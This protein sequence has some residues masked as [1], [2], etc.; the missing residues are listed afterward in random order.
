[1]NTIGDR[2]KI[3][4]ER[5]N[6]TQQELASTIN[7]TKQTIYK[8]EN[9]I[10]TNIPSDKLEKIS[11]ALDVSP[12]YLMGWEENLEQANTDVLVDLAV[13]LEAMNHVEKLLKLDDEAKNAVYN[14]IDILSAKKKL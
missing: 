11:A 7:S 8:Y 9:N 2:I 1:M 12:A 13:D 3:M 10:I 14:M 6:I 4:R 5:R